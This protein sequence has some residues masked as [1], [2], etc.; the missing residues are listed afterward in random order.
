MRKIKIC[1]AFLLSLTL[2]SLTAC[3][4]KGSAATAD[5]NVVEVDFG[6]LNYE[7]NIGE[8]VKA[9]IQNNL[10]SVNQ[11]EDTQESETQENENSE[12]KTQNS[13]T[14]SKAS[15]SS[16]YNPTG[17]PANLSWFDDCVFMGDSLTLG[18]SYY[19]DLTGDL[20]NAQFVC[21]AGLGW[22]NSQWSLYDENEV[23]P[24]YNGEKV[25]L[26]DAVV[27][28][29]ANK[30]IIGLGMNDVGIFGVDETLSYAEE[31]IGKVRA[32]T[33]DVQIYLQTITPMIEIAEYDALNN[34]LIKEYDEA[35]EVFAREQNCKFINSWA[36]LADENGKLPYELCQDPD[37]L[38]LHLTNEGCEIWANCIL[39]SVY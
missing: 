27:L 37:A 12:D 17:I 9:D 1:I 31:F 28:T 19:N 5:E 25:L 4:A 23:H 34:P 16:R 15:A 2:V 38:G 14:A 11:E 20:G 24:I 10:A 33:P 18:L 35:L 3:G 22:C 36:A 32:K 26:E 29:G 21:S 39:H 30:A 8:P 13:E 6:N 7:G